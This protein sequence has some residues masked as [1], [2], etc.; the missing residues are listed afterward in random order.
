MALKGGIMKGHAYLFD[1]TRMSRRSVLS[2]GTSHPR[3][4][5]PFV[6]VWMLLFIAMLCSPSLPGYSV[7][8]HEE[9][10][11]LLW[12][13]G[14]QPLLLLRFPESSKEQLG[15]AH[16][17]AYGGAV[18]QDL[19][20]YPFGSAEFSDLTHYVRSGDFVREMRLQS[21]DI[22]EYAFALGALSHYASDIAGHPAVNQAVSIRYPALRKKFGK[23]VRYA[24]GKTAHMRTEFGFDM[25]QVAKNRYASEQYHD[26][27]G[28]KVSKSLLERVFPITYGL[29]LKDVLPRADLTIGSY[30]FAISRLIPEMTKVALKTHKKDMM[31][32]KPT[33]A[34]KKFLYRLSRSDYER[35]W[36]KDYLKPGLGVRIFAGLLRFMPKV[37]PFKALAFN[38]P[39]PE[40]EELYFKSINTTVDQYR[41][42]LENVRKDSLLPA[43]R[44]LDDG[45]MTKPAEYSLADRAYAKL[46]VKL[47]KSKFD[48][49]TTELRANLLHFY[50]DLSIPM[51]TKKDKALWQGVLT[52]LE[53]L[54]SMTPDPALAATSS[55]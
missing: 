14:I 10:V 20:Y 50:S 39:T 48:R 53:Q 13:D 5:S 38:N 42:F 41:A 24:Q 55:E 3:G 9:I 34:R 44:D 11:D 19:G 17:F 32:E 43:N 1:V 27:I 37:G 40:M 21:Q 54:K 46:L 16:A 35:D 12:T 51:E 31:S 25:V 47:A 6:R 52:G 49:T 36:G 15:E 28:F 2:L 18:I 26:F 8:T 29:E 23:S 22:N 33:A 30:R 4:R 7:L 45:N